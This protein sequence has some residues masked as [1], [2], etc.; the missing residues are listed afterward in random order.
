ME[1]V[2]YAA[3]RKGSLGPDSRFFDYKDEAEDW[4]SRQAHPEEYEVR[5]SDGSFS[6]VD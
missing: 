4:I 2:F 5:E 1:E 3:Y 6:S